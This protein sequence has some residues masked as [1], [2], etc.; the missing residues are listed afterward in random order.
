[1]RW[2]LSSRHFER[3]REISIVWREAHVLSF[4]ACEAATRSGAVSLRRSERAA[5]DAMVRRSADLLTRSLWS[6]A[7]P[8]GMTFYRLRREFSHSAIPI[9]I[10]SLASRM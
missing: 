3:S 1:M 5:I 7:P 8:G 2:L 4:R 6:A 9:Y 10:V